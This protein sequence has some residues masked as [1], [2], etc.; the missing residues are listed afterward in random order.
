LPVLP[1]L[2]ARFRVTLVNLPGFHGSKPIAP[3][4]ARYATHLSAILD[5]A[6]LDHPIVMANGFGGTVALAMAVQCGTR[7]GKLVMSDVAAGFPPAGQEAFAVMARKVTD[8]GIASVATIAAMRVF[9]DEY[10]TAHPEAIAQRAQVLMGIEPSAFVAACQS[11]MTDD[12]TSQLTQIKNPTL[13]VCGERDAATPPV[14]CRQ[15]AATIPGARYV[16]LPGC[17]HCP[18]LEQPQQFLAAVLPF[19]S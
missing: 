13:V 7:L 3:G 19:L 18:P 12:I 14:L 4:I 6:R 10:L 1:E 16:E 5:A 15:V 8:E 2:A 17:G 9:H 11:L